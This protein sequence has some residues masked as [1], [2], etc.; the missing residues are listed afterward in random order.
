MPERQRKQRAPESLRASADLIRRYLGRL[1]LVCGSAASAHRTNTIRALAIMY[2]R[3]FIAPI[4]WGL[5]HL[6]H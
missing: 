5:I 1:P 6:S 2:S 3:E 4:H